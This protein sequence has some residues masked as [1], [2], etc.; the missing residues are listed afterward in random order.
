MITQDYIDQQ[1]Q[2]EINRLYQETLGRQVD[3]EG[4]AN[5]LRSELASEDIK[6]SLAQSEEGQNL[7]KQTYQDILGRE[8][9]PSGL[10]TYTNLLG[11]E[12]AYIDPFKGNEL[13]FFKAQLQLSP[14]YL[15]NN[16]LQGDAEILSKAYEQYLGRP[17]DASGLAFWTEKL[18]E[19]NGDMSVI[20]NAIKTSDEANLRAQLGRQ[21][22]EKETHDFMQAMDAQR[23]DSGFGLGDFFK[24]AIPLAVAYFAPSLGAELFAT[25]GAATTGLASLPDSVLSAS[26]AFGA[27]AGSS[28]ISPTVTVAQTASNSLISPSIS[29]VFANTVTQPYEAS[30]TP[31]TTGNEIPYDW[32]TINTQPNMTA[33]NAANAAGAGASNTPLYT[34]QMTGGTDFSNVA[35][36]EGYTSQGGPTETSSTDPRNIKKVVDALRTMTGSSTGYQSGIGTGYA[37]PN[38]FFKPEYQPIMEET[39]TNQP[40]YLGQLANLLRG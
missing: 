31:I 34:Q 19:A 27:G 5:Y 33:V 16:P 29:D 13:D 14:E 21:P 23:H 32:N 9:D 17:I 22:T 35:P 18:K 15:K 4:L 26:E 25:E 40:V 2:D 11:R 39:K 7:I 1:R 38:P 8:A 10:Q 6:K 37:M 24:I 12:Q 30:T 3:P 20:Q 36:G 28:L